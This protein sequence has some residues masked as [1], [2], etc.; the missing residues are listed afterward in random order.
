[1]SQ[2][3]TPSL[4]KFLSVPREDFLHYQ[5]CS[6]ACAGLNPEGMRRLVGA[7]RILSD[8]AEMGPDPRMKGA[9][10]CYLVPLDDVDA[11]RAALRAAKA[12]TGE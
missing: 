12:G 4:P 3:H 10:G 9:T 2:E 11:L 8:T 7:A 5:K 6:A 1:M